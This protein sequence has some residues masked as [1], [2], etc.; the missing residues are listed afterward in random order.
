MLYQSE[1][2]YEVDGTGNAGDYAKRDQE[3]KMQQQKTMLR[4]YPSVVA[5]Q[6]FT[7][8]GATSRTYLLEQT[9]SLP[10]SGTLSV[11][12]KSGKLTYTS[13]DGR[14]LKGVNN[15]ITS[16]EHGDVLFLNDGTATAQTI[17]NKR[18]FT[19]S[20]PTAPSLIDNAVVLNKIS[21]FTWRHWDNVT[22][23]VA[24]TNLSYRGLLEYSPSDFIMGSQRPLRLF[25]GKG[26][27]VVEE[28]I[29]SSIIQDNIG[30][31]NGEF[32]PYLID[33]N[34]KL[35]RVSGIDAETNVIAIRNIDGD[36]ISKEIA[37]GEVLTGQY[38]FIGLR[39][40]DAALNLLNDS[41]GNIAGFLPYPSTDI[42]KNQGAKYSNEIGANPV[43][44]LM[45]KHSGEYVARNIKGL[46]ILEVIKSLTEMDGRQ[47]VVE[48][49]GAMIYS[50]STFRETNIRLG[51]DS[52]ASDI[53]VSKMFD[54]P[55]Q[56]VIIGDIVAENERIEVTVKDLEK[57]RSA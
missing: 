52:G 54:S 37:I 3:F 2:S 1:S 17:Q 18:S 19:P 16:Y 57:M 41:A 39:T 27:G 50:R 10:S 38:G 35:Y 14:L 49:N 43:L 48:E 4:D 25:D 21:D 7:G 20:L 47:L 22:G 33:S 34:E 24:K 5:L 55:N 36:L 28:Y 6:T 8:G 51:L 53:Q 56:V 40:S 12:G 15:E 13:V 31:E 30:T 44:S 32:P 45:K 11:I 23:K 26:G 29:R 46:N 42:I 9:V